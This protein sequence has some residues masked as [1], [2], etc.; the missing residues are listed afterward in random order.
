MSRQKESCKQQNYSSRVH[1]PLE[2]A[3]QLHQ[4]DVIEYMKVH[5]GEQ[6]V[7]INENGNASP[8]RKRSVR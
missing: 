6:F 4:T 2:T 8:S 1:H 5:F 7:F 3:G